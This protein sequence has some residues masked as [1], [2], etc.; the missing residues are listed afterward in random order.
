MYT[1]SICIFGTSPSK[2][3]AI[4]ECVDSLHTFSREIDGDGF[5]SRLLDI[6]DRCTHQSDDCHECDGEHD[7]CDEKL[8]E[9]KSFVFHTVNR[10]DRVNKED[11]EDFSCF[12]SLILL[13][14]FLYKSVA[15]EKRLTIIHCLLLSMIYFLLL[16]A[17]VVM[18]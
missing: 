15:S 7:E 13:N 17:Y 18:I 2:S 5:L 14:I 12:Q 11:R 16:S 4:S 8:D 1:E 10:E 9:C 3:I 6:A